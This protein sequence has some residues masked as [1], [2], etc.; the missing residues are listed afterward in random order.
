M[1]TNKNKSKTIIE[2]IS[3]DCKCQFNSTACNSKQKWINKICG[4]KSYPKRNKNYSWN[5][6][7]CIS[8]KSKYLKSIADTSMTERDEIIIVIDDYYRIIIVKCFNKKD[9]Y[10]SNKKDKY[11]SN[12]CYEYCFNKLS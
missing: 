11:Y 6:S 3:C 4:Y 7:T 1:L 2:H 12:K 8:V 9:K 5:P 10:Y